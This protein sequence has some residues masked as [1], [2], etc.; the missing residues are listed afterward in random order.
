MVRQQLHTNQVR[1][2]SWRSRDTTSSETL[3]INGVIFWEP[4]QATGPL[5]FPIL[6]T[7]LVDTLTIATTLIAYYE[8]NKMHTCNSMGLC[9]FST[10]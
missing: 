1:E 4:T 8:W 2:R 6:C 10:N 5:S 7:I 3:E 9:L